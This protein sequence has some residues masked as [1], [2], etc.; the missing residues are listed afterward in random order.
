MLCRVALVRTDVSEEHS[1]SI[2]RATVISELGT[3]AVTIIRRTLRINT[4][5]WWWRLSFPPKHRFLQEPHGVTFQKTAFFIVP[6]VRWT[7]DRSLEFITLG[8][9]FRKRSPDVSCTTMHG[10]FFR[11]FFRVFCGT[12]DPSVIPS[13]LLPWSSACWLF[14]FHKLKI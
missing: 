14:L 9:S 10:T 12:Q 8:L 7:G 5:S 1:A 4:S 2:I 3:L 11:R 13:T 6:T